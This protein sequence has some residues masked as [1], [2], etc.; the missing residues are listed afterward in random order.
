MDG[1][2]RVQDD[3]A[4][5]QGRVIRTE[6]PGLVRGRVV[7]DD[8]DVRA[9]VQDNDVAAIGRQPVAEK[10]R[11]IGTLLGSTWVSDDDVAAVERICAGAVIAGDLPALH[12]RFYDD[13][14]RLVSN[15]G[16]RTRLR[17]AL[18]RR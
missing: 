6:A 1:P 2:V 7:T 14:P 10:L 15:I 9:W 4:R 8:D 17:I 16:Q 5:M 11:M 3:Y 18:T 12:D 13:L